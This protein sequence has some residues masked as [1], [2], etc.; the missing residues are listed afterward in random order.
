MR[1][2]RHRQDEQPQTTANIFGRLRYIWYFPPFLTP[3]LTPKRLSRE[4][5][6]SVCRFVVCFLIVVFTIAF[7]LSLIAAAGLALILATLFGRAFV[8]PYQAALPSGT[9]LPARDSSAPT[10]AVAPPPPF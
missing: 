1:K 4:D 8:V 3:N 7:I 5:F 2:I 9:G 10:F 6:W